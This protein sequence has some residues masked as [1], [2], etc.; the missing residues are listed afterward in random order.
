M[1]R[2]ARPGHPRPEEGA[3]RDPLPDP[4]AARRQ[5][6]GPGPARRRFSDGT[7]WAPW[8]TC[9][10][11]G[12]PWKRK[13]SF[14]LRDSHRAS[15]Q[16]WRISAFDALGNRREAEFPVH[17]PE[18]SGNRAPCPFITAPTN[19]LAPGETLALDASRSEDPEKKPMTFRWDF[20]DGGHGLWRGGASRLRE[21]GHLRDHPH[22]FRRPGW[23][24]GLALRAR[25]R[26]R[27]SAGPRDS[28]G[29]LKARRTLSIRKASRGTLG[30]RDTLSKHGN[31]PAEASGPGRGGEGPASP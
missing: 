10:S 3:T 23:G 29:T 5:R 21:D 19:L 8:I 27:S 1:D 17:V 26:A 13:S 11:M 31:G 7:A 20:G 6:A 12:G 22:R 14:G 2:G 15:G 16:V 28:G 9:A 30:P 25:G 18:G 4:G 24:K